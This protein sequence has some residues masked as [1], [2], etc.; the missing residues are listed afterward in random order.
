MAYYPQGCDDIISAHVCG[1]CGDELSRVRGVAFINK[2]YYP[3]VAADPE[4][5]EGKTLERSPWRTERTS[6]IR[7]SRAANLV[8]KRPNFALTSL[9][10][11]NGVPYD[12]LRLFN[13]YVFHSFF[14]KCIWK[15]FSKFNITCFHSFCCFSGISISFFWIFF[16]NFYISFSYIF[17]Y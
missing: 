15:I 2:S 4:N 11:N 16:I 6:R 3:S 8:C 5:I 10:V 13:L 1:T 14:I 17:C 7:W 9:A 12:W